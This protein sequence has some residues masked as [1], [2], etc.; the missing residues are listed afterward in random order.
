MSSY[1]D[2]L[3]SSPDI[4]KCLVVW[5][6]PNGHPCMTG[7]LK[8]LAGTF[9]TCNATVGFNRDLGEVEYCNAPMSVA[10]DERP[11]IEGPLS[12]AASE[13]DK[14]MRV[15]SALLE[16]QKNLREGMMA[17]EIVTLLGVALKGI[18]KVGK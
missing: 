3:D 16:A 1:R 12:E 13:N 18:R 7:F 9:R 5:T 2:K 8:P 17:A 4:A 6:C 15:G 14:R 11:K 10:C